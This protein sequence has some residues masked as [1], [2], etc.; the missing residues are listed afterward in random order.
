[1]SWGSKLRWVFLCFQMGVGGLFAVPVEALKADKFTDAR[2]IMAPFEAGEETIEVIIHLV[3]PSEAKGTLRWKSL[4]SRQG[5]RDKIHARQQQL[6]DGLDPDGFRLRHRLE[7]QATLSAYVTLAGLKALSTDPRVDSIEPIFLLEPHLSQGISLMNA[8]TVRQSYSGQ[9]VS[10]AI[11]D[12]GVDYTHAALGGGGFPNT[13]VI[14]GYDFGDNDAD[15][16]PNTQAHGTCCAGIA[17]GDLGST[18]DYIGGVAHRAKLYALKISAGSGGSAYNSDIAAAW[19]W[20]VTHQYDDPDNPILVI[21]T[22][23]GGGQFFSACDSDSFVLTTAANN[24]VA[25]G[26]T[27]LVSSGND[28]YCSAISSPSCISSIISVGAVWD[29]SLGTYSLCVSDG[30]C[31]AAGGSASCDAG[32]YSTSQVTGADVV[33]A[34]SNTASFLDVLAPSHNAYT[35]D[36][37]GAEGY[38]TGDYYNSFGGTSAACP[39]AAGAVACLQSAAKASGGSYLTPAEVKAVLTSTGDDVTDDK[40][41]ITKPRINLGTAIEGLM[42]ETPPTAQGQDVQTT[43]GTPVTIV[44]EATDEGLPDPPGA[45]SY[46]I[47]SL[48]D[49]GTLTDPA[50]SLIETVPYALVGDGDQVSYTP[51]CFAGTDNFLFKANDGGTLPDGGDSNDATVS[52]TVAAVRTLYTATMDSDPNWTFDGDGW[53]WGV[54]AGEGGE[55]GGP[56]PA[57]GYTGASVV[58]YNLSGDYANNLGATEWATTTAFDCTGQTGVTLT[59]CRWLNLERSL[60]DH[61]YIA[62]SND[63]SNWATVWENPDSPVEDA[64]WSVQ[65]IDISAVADNQPAVSVRWGLGPTD[66]SWRYSGWNI[67]DVAVIGEGTFTPMAGD[68][69]PDCDVDFDDLALLISYWLQTCGGGDCEGTDLLADGIVNLN[70][71]QRL[72]QNWLAT[73]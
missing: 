26:M 25:A 48:P 28:G 42:G 47:T 34:Y 38:S 70:D 50:A 68:F 37:A 32:E 29:A 3:P 8:S 10:V 17:A 11:C 72:A 58:G 2:E 9:G 44:L 52:V 64:A 1:M 39:Y 41:A 5:F 27:L 36:I 24:A 54:P 65:E 22:S 18:G 60:Y 4:T 67:D 40:A 56:D 21:S 13:K 15:P 45:L 43:F 57:S 12:T 30:S 59:F 46:L 14:G 49:H 33:T 73:Y 6:L 53:A 71:F 35:P 61:A 23:F 55:Y 31:A 51:G 66:S 7:N 20:C 63:G 62:V 16:M 69:E 19:D